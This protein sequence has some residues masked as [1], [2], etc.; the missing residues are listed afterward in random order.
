[1]KHDRVIAFEPRERILT[2]AKQYVDS[3]ETFLEDGDQA[4][5]LLLKAMKLADDTLKHEIMVVLGSF[6]KEEIAWPLVDLMTDASESEEVRHNA[7]I[8]LS[9]IAPFLKNS[10][11]LVDRLVREIESSDAERGITRPTP[12]DGGG[13]LRQRY[14]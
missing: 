11:A 2:K 13:I 10:Q 4:V 8:Q 1:M 9:V 6:A 12:W 3:V 7:A 5:S 14:P